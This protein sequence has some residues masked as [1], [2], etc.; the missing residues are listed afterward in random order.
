LAASPD[1]K[2]FGNKK[3]GKTAK[4][5]FSVKNIAKP[6]APDLIIDTVSIDQTDPAQFT[7]VSD[8]D[9]CSGKTLKPGKSC[10]FDVAF[11]PSSVNTQSATIAITSND[12]DSPQV[13][14]L[15][16]VGK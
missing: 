16:G 15:T 9:L 3:L 2:N 14:Q 6:G 8:K 1:Y 11:T 7:V 13:I 4:A 5:T 12:L 10:R